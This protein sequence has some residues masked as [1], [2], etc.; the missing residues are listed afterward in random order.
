MRCVAGGGAVLGCSALQSTAACTH[1]HGARS[2]HA[3]MHMRTDASVRACACQPGLPAPPGNR[4]KTR[5]AGRRTRDAGQQDRPVPRRAPSKLSRRCRAQGRQWAGHAV[6]WP[7]ARRRAGGWAPAHV[8]HR[9]LGVAPGGP[10]PWPAA[11]A[12]GGACRRRPCRDPRV[13][14]GTPAILL[15]RWLVGRWCSA[16]LSMT[17]DEGKPRA[18]AS[19]WGRA[20]RMGM[21]IGRA[22]V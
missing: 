2:M 14:P 1:V 15:Q 5:D 12:P 13:P 4:R 18:G 19:H 10:S 11:G 3:C 16:P 7:M 22:H 21:E 8:R 20:C 17:H 9:T 6:P